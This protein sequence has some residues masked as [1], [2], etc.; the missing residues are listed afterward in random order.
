MSSFKKP[1]V[2]I[3]IGPPGSGKGTQA[4]L[5][6]EKFGLYF[7]DTSKIVGRVIEEAKKGEY[8]KVEGEKYY[9]E[10]EKRL[11]EEGKLWDPPF[12]TFIV[13]KK[14]KE[15]AKEGKGISLIGSPRTLYEAERITPLLKKLYGAK[16]ITVILIK[17]SERESIWRNSHRRECGLI[18]HP[19]L[20]TK[21]TEKLTECPI[22]GSELVTRRDDTSKIIKTR[23]REYEE[24][25]LPLVDYLKK[26][27]VK[28]KKVNGEQSVADVFENVLEAIK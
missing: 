10:K 25:T 1:K 20:Y 4:N 13:K 7:W 3:L 11:R 22:D 18:R 8:V 28:I 23:L 16:N 26:Q 14:L 27:R 21:E 2:I 5:L 15:V 9:F 19:I 24:R 12:L 17:L 6:A